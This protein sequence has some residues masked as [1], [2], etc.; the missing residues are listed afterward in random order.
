MYVNLKLPLKYCTPC[1]DGTDF[2]FMP[3]N[4]TFFAGSTTNVFS[5]TIRDDDLFEI[6]ETFD[7][8][9][10]LSSST[11]LSTANRTTTVVIMDNDRKCYYSK[12]GLLNLRN[13]K[14]EGSETHLISVVK[15]Y[16]LHNFVHSTSIFH[17][18]LFIIIF[19]QVLWSTS[20]S[21][22]IVLRKTVEWQKFS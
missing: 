20:V 11:P 14:C 4:I 18:L 21:R 16:F 19:V 8:N 15:N 13:Q 5:I 7:L 17:C 3:L 6:D 2:V 22:C 10:T 1:T 9:M 12:H